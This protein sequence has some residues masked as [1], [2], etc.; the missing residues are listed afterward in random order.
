MYQRNTRHILSEIIDINTLARF[1][2]IESRQ[3]I[4]RHDS[5]SHI[6]EELE[7]L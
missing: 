7:I 3:G 6:R 2:T 4:N 1:Y 5:L